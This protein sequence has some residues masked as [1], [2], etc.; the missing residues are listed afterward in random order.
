MTTTGPHIRA[1]SQPLLRL[2][3]GVLLLVSTAI[4][5]VCG[6]TALARI[7]QTF[8]G[9]FVWENGFVPAVGLPSWTGSASGLRY[10]SWIERIG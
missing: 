6:Y 10:H 8:P 2:G 5:G 1:A 3:V 9:F 4:V 7:G